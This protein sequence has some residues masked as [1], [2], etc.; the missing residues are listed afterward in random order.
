MCYSSL[1]AKWACWVITPYKAWSI[2]ITTQMLGGYYL[3]RFS[4][5]V[6]FTPESTSSSMKGR[7]LITENAASSY[8]HRLEMTSRAYLTLKIL[9][10]LPLTPRSHQK[11]AV[12]S[13]LCANLLGLMLAMAHGPGLC[14]YYP[15]TVSGTCTRKWSP[16][17]LL[18]L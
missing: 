12:S 11:T 7:T 18:E 1:S 8:L 10:V 4:S 13:R 6:R 14:L 2:I 17:C 9:S 16:L 3:L 15:Q 5:A